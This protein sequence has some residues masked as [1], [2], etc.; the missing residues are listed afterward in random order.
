MFIA[1]ASVNN[2]AS[3]RHQL[4]I[5]VLFGDYQK[6]IQIP[7]VYILSPLPLPYSF[8]IMIEMEGSKGEDFYP[9][10]KEK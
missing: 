1:A 9:T 2:I 4:S 10:R 7:I 8:K 5:P 6:L 3:I